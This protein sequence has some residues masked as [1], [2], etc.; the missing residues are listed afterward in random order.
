MRFLL[1][2]AAAPLALL[3][4]AGPAAADPSIRVLPSSAQPGSLVLLKSS[5][6]DGT[7]QLEY[8]SPAFTGTAVAKMR[9][10][11]G[12]TH[13]TLKPGL[14]PGSYEVRG[15]CRADRSGTVVRA[16][17]TVTG[18]S[19]GTARGAA[20]DPS[21]DVRADSAAAAPPPPSEAPQSDGGETHRSPD[22]TVPLAILAAGLLLVAGVGL[23]ARRRATRPSG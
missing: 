20:L 1:A 7:E 15:E 11:T 3:L 17:V 9:S 23:A 21:S 2:A 8:T 4:S 6:D 16:G 13:A 10:T 19:P 5:C 22:P 12:T 18:D 14:A